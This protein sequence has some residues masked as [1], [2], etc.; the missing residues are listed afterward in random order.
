M[1]G[2][3]GVALADVAFFSRA[4]VGGGLTLDD[5]GFF[6]LGLGASAD[7]DLGGRVACF[8]LPRL[9]AHAHHPPLPFISL[10]FYRIKTA[11]QLSRSCLFY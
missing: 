3:G 11:T 4:R 10:F 1:G 6:D 8:F 5:V 9:A 2:G 7:L